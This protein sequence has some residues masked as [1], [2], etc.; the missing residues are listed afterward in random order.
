LAKLEKFDALAARALLE[1]AIAADPNH[2][3]S[4]SALA[5]AWSALGYESKAAEE[6]KR[7]L[8]PSA[9]LPR[10]QRLAIEGN[11]REFARDLP[12]AIEIYRTLSNF[13]PTTLS[14]RCI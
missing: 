9:N 5:Q 10:E 11:Y 7:A 2:P 13:F 3:L 14:T 4:H 8:D 12:A 1:K 6:A